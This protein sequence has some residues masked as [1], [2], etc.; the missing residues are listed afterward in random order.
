MRKRQSHKISHLKSAVGE[1]EANFEEK[2]LASE[3]AVQALSSELRT[4]KNALDTLK[5]KEKAVS[6]HVIKKFSFQECLYILITMW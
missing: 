1:S 2:T 5:H 3:N 4:T 6:L